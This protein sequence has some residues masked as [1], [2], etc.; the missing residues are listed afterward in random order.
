M[1]ISRFSISIS[2]TEAPSPSISF[3]FFQQASLTSSVQCSKYLIVW[4]L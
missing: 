1:E 2:M 3:T 4:C